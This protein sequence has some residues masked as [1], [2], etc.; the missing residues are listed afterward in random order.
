M[1]DYLTDFIAEVYDEIGS[2][3]D[4]SIQRLSGWFL[5]YSNIGKLNNLIGTNYAPYQYRDG[6]GNITGYAITTGNITNS[7]YSIY[8]Y[9]FEYYYYKNSALTVLQG[10]GTPG[11]DWL[12]LAEGDSKISKINKNEV[13]KTFRGMAND[14]KE[15]LDKA[16]KMYLK[17]GAV[18]QQIAGDDTVGVSNYVINEYDRIGFDRWDKYQ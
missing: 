13:A 14:A 18:A 3:N 5:D 10:I 16:V 11:G 12:S 15:T 2:P 6:G 1:S 8:K 7:E 9:L 17:Y 4:Y